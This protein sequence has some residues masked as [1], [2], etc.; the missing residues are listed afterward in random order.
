M[1]RPASAPR[2]LRPTAEARPR[3]LKA[4]VVRPLS[5]LD[6]AALLALWLRR[7]EPDPEGAAARLVARFD[8]LGGAVG[9]D[10]PAL[11]RAAALSKAALEDVAL[12]RELAARLARAAAARRPVISAWSALQ[13]Y[14][15]TVQANAPREQFRVLFLDHRNHLMVDEILAE[16]SVSH[17]P[18]FSAG[19]ARVAARGRVPDIPETQRYVRAVIDCYLALSAGRRVASARDC[20]PRGAG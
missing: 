20:R 18:V 2:A 16:G 4:D 3:S 10:R 11:A 1:S 7:W 13:A 14:A 17:A 15:R 6:D 12:L 19:P 9:A 8:G 5:A